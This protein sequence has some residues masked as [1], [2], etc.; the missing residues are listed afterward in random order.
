MAKQFITA[1]EVELYCVQGITELP[2]NDD[3][4][5]TDIA[6][7]RARELGVRIYHAPEAAPISPPVREETE[8][9]SRGGPGSTY[10]PA[11][12]QANQNVSRADI[13]EAVIAGLKA[14]GVDPP[15]NLDAIINRVMN[16]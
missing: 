11:S 16:T 7:E 1:R 12:A 10:S 4:V 14:E 15:R 2:A 8:Q 9:A 5:V 3:V 13:K 6:R